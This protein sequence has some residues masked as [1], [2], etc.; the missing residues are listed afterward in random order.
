MIC[1][2]VVIKSWNFKPFSANLQTVNRGDK[3]VDVY[4]ELNSCF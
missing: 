1:I 4:F 3:Y 2:K